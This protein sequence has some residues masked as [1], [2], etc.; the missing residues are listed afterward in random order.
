MDVDGNDISHGLN[1]ARD[2]LTDGLSYAQSTLQEGT[3]RTLQAADSV[4]ARAQKPGALNR[5]LSF[6]KTSFNRSATSAAS[7]ASY[8]GAKLSSGASQAV[9]MAADNI[10][11][12]EDMSEHVKDAAR[13]VRQTAHNAKEV[14]KDKAESAEDR[15]EDALFYLRTKVSAALDASSSLVSSMRNSLDK[16][17]EMSKT[18]ARDLRQR[19]TA[20]QNS[21]SEVFDNSTI[22]FASS[23]PEQ[24]SW[25]GSLR[26]RLG[27]ERRQTYGQRLQEL[28]T[29]LSQSSKSVKEDIERLVNASSGPDP[30]YPRG[31]QPSLD[32]EELVRGIQ[33]KLGALATDLEW[34]VSSSDTSPSTLT[35]ATRIANQSMNVAKKVAKKTINVSYDVGTSVASGYN[36]LSSFLHDAS[37]AVHMQL[38][39]RVLTNNT[40]VEAAVQRVARAHQDLRAI[41]WQVTSAI[42]RVHVSRFP[43]TWHDAVDSEWESMEDDIWQ[44]RRE[45]RVTATQAAGRSDRE[46]KPF[47]EYCSKLEEAIE[48]SAQAIRTE[49][50]DTP[51]LSVSA[52]V[53]STSS[54]VLS[55]PASLTTSRSPFCVLTACVQ[56]EL[57]LGKQC[58]QCMDTDEHQQHIVSSL[59]NNVH[60]AVALLRRQLHD[61]RTIGK[62]RVRSV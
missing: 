42:H 12:R 4:K 21:I 58:D 27:L 14:V 61:L 22:S 16:P 5:T 49:V 40:R 6:L 30:L 25:L 32:R 3:E 44:A 60:D 38:S 7:T 31:T 2:G 19:A 17:G 41:K 50:R 48:G 9:D 52:C 15:L 24:T 39:T 11:P 37:D 46:N 57:L 26:Q 53:L 43:D 29:T 51:S 10:P 20:L 55:V 36:A 56:V 62:D 18:V 8:A 13:T 59:Q 34:M 54:L 1:K 33:A 47:F 45:L 35:K 23:V 28:G